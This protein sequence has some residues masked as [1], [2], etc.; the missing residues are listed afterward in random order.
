MGTLQCK[1]CSGAITV[2][3]LQELVACFYAGWRSNNCP[4]HFKRRTGLAKGMNAQRD[5][6]REYKVRDQ[7]TGVNATVTASSNAEAK[8]QFMAK[9]KERMPGVRYDPDKLTVTMLNVE[10]HDRN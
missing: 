5:P 2:N 9:S 3:T 8:L 10:I 6:N 4:E 7:A 1:V